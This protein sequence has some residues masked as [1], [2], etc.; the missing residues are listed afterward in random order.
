[1]A[2]KVVADPKTES[3]ALEPVWMSRDFNLPDAAVV[4]N[5]IVF[6]VSTGE[7][8]H[9]ERGEDKRLLNTRPAVLYA[10]DAKTGRELYNS[11]NTMTGW[12]HFSGLAVANGRVFAVDHDSNL[13]CF[14]LESK[15]GK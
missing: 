14:G 7:N 11:G 2:F 15:K 3:P 8:A 4:A 12:V 5:G 1:M 9:Q 13:Y 10:L 6:A